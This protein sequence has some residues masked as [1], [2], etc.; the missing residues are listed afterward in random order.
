[1]RC[2]YKRAVARACVRACVYP[3]R[4]RWWCARSGGSNVFARVPAMRVDREAPARPVAPSCA[5]GL[6]ASAV[7]EQCPRPMPDHATHASSRPARIY[8]RTEMSLKLAQ[9]THTHI[10]TS[11]CADVLTCGARTRITRA[12]LGVTNDEIINPHVKLLSTRA[13][14]HANRAAAFTCAPLP[15][16]AALVP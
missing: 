9:H 3:H 15:L 11:A 14:M 1:M 7:C 6:D 16:P 2:T 12:F 4:D 5:R 8:G 10:Q 13:N